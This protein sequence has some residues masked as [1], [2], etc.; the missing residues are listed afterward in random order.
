MTLDT[1]QC[2]LGDGIK[3]QVIT[4]NDEYPGPNLEVRENA[5]VHVKVINNLFGGVSPTIHW[6]GIKMKGGY[7][8]YD[9]VKG[10]TQCGID[11]KQSFTYRRVLKKKILIQSP[12]LVL[13]PTSVLN[14]TLV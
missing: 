12:I 10:I 8:W 6:H 1:D 4:I 3:R 2:V 9:G 7:M 5:L 14:P 13:G 11:N